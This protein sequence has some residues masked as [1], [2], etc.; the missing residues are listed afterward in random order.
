MLG[1]KNRS[2][3]DEGRNSNLSAS[4]NSRKMWGSWKSRRNSLS[5]S[6]LNENDCKSTELESMQCGPSVSAYRSTSDLKDDCPD[7][8]PPHAIHVKRDISWSH[9]ER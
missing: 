9:D 6:R 3:A 8:A 2:T 1:Q 4:A 7:V 5:F